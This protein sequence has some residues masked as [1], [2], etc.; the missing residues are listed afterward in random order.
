[1]PTTWQIGDQIQGRWEIYKILQGGAGIV[2]IV[3]D[4]Q[5]REPFAAKTFRDEIFDCNPDIAPRFTQE[6]LA[7]IKLD[8]H[9]NIARARM[10]EKIEGK[11]FL[12][13]EY[14]SGGD[15]GAWIGTPR[16]TEDLPQVLRFAIHLCDGMTHA[17]LK[18][19]RV[20]RDI[21]PRN[22]LITQDGTL[23][24][25]DFGLA[26]L[27]EDNN[28]GENLSAPRANQNFSL[29]ASSVG[30]CTHMAPEQFDDARRVDV[31][32]DVYSFGVMLYQMLT[33]E[34]PFVGQTWDEVERLHKTQDPPR[35][36]H[37]DPRLT[38]VIQTCLEKDPRRRF[39]NFEQVRDWLADLYESLV[40]ASAP[41]PA[42]GAELTS[43][44][45][46]NKGSSLDNLGRH[47]EAIAC[48]DHALG[49]NAQLV[50]AWF[51]K[52]VAL[53]ALRRVEEAVGCYDRALGLHPASEQA[54][55]NKGVALKALGRAQE[56][57]V[58]Y[59]RALELNPRYANAWVNK[60]V[61][62]RAAG[63][64]QD[65]LKHYE[66]AIQLNPSDENA[67]SN[68]GNA[69]YSLRR[70]EE[71]IACYKRALELSPRLEMTWLNKGM[72]LMALGRFEE[73]VACYDAAL[74]INPRLERAWLYKGS[75]LVNGFQRYREALAYFGEAQRLGAREAEQGLALCR[76]KL[77]EQ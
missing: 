21:K 29:T 25:T 12:F 61:M 58:C 65:A 70:Q 66:R 56:A 62:L 36:N 7:W 23:K 50:A 39:A 22:C 38:T 13:L 18:G 33:G 31:R 71:A 8:A 14:V 73:A 72:A 52:G 24:V 57:I 10:V 40:G 45:W 15:L 46:N 17:M 32:A 47:E 74:S 42:C 28:R 37:A 20:H 68:K 2:Y 41:Q 35:L 34:L 54:W 11:P 30:T 27:L 55:S 53:Y 26:K 76:Q 67:W 49:L 3:Y 43:A 75:A 5:F 59:D 77:G 69:L 51:N 44:E 64:T 4:H 16:L 19:I 9:P 63:R 1:M 60:G 6:A 48:Y